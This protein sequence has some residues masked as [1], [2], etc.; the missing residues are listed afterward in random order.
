MAHGPRLFDPA[1]KLVSVARQLLRPLTLAAVVGL[2]GP[3]RT[4]AAGSGVDLVVS[5]FDVEQP[6]APGS[7]VVRSVRVTNRGLG[8]LTVRLEPRAVQLLDD[9][10]TEFADTEDPL[11]AGH[12][13][14]SVDELTLAAGAGQDVSVQVAIPEDMP[15]DDYLLGLLVTPVPGT[16]T[17]MQVINSIGTLISI[18]VAGDRLR[19]LELVSHSLPPFVVGDQVTGTVRVKDTGTTLVSPW[20][21][22]TAAD[23]LF[24]HQL[25]DI[26]VRD[27]NRIGPGTSRDLSYTWNAGIVAG[28]FR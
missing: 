20:L 3:G 21:E 8:P 25:A 2:L 12:V 6:A 15:P 23:A 4:I 14:L 10:K 16:P 18:D 11:W 7:S 22:A 1:L 9:G 27:Q 13:T 19:S 24:G 28:R 5:T 26:Q 17:T